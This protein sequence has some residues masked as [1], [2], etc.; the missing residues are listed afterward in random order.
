ML[1]SDEVINQLTELSFRYRWSLEWAH[2]FLLVVIVVRDEVLDRI[3][4]ENSLNSHRVRPARVLLWAMTKVG[5]LTL[6][7]DL[8]M[9]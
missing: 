2:K 3:F 8:L 4:W 9:V 6:G 7:N 5:L 1:L